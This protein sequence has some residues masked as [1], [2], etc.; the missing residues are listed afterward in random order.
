MSEIRIAICQR[1]GGVADHTT[2]E[3]PSLPLTA[4]AWAYYHE[5]GQR[6]ARGV[7][8]DPYYVFPKKHIL[9]L[10]DA[11]LVVVSRYRFDQWYVQRADR[12]QK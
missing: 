5:L 6:R 3:H 8:V 1:C 11:G 9:R 4:A 7:M 12:M 2:Q 10:E